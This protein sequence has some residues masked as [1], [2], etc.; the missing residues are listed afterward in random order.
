MSTLRCS[1]Q[2]RPAQSQALSLRSFTCR[3][4]SIRRCVTLAQA[5]S[6]STDTPIRFTSTVSRIL[7]AGAAAL[8]LATVPATAALAELQTVPADQVT[9][10]AK[11]LRVQTVNKGRVWLLFILGASSLFGAT[12]LAENNE[13]FF[14]AI[15]RANKAMAAS[16]AALKQ[17]QERS[18]EEQMQFDQRLVEVQAEREEDALL[19]DAV[20]AGIA[21]ARRPPALAAVEPSIISAEALETETTYPAELEAAPM[22]VSSQ[23]EEES[24][25]EEPSTSDS[26]SITAAV[27]AAGAA[28]ASRAPLFE[29]GGDQ[30][31]SSMKQ[32]ENRVLKEMSVE[33]LQRELESRKAAAGQQA[34]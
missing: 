34:E 22:E 28:G 25:E 11:P 9:S 30:I 24:E 20:A 29:I 23:Q 2:L 3:T 10:L 12:I 8:V 5:N 4:N 7:G 15:S 27:E 31:E 14:P 19:E 18:D 26:E 21:A 6:H 13:T 16:A 1:L 32:Y 33:D 17:K